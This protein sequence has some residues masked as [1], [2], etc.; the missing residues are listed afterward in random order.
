MPNHSSLIQ[1]SALRSQRV[2][3]VQASVPRLWPTL[4]VPVQVQLAKQMAQLLCRMTSPHPV[5]IREGSHAER[6]EDE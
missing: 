1:L 2:S 4:P 6:G 5:P 3:P